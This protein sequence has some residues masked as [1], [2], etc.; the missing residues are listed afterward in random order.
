MFFYI[1]LL[2]T[3]LPTYLPTCLPACLP[4]CLSKMCLN[5]S[6]SFFRHA[7]WSGRGSTRYGASTFPQR[8]LWRSRN[9]EIANLE[10]G[11]AKVRACL[12]STSF[13]ESAVEAEWLVGAS[14]RKVELCLIWSSTVHS[15]ATGNH[16][17]NALEPPC[18]GFQGF[19]AD[20]WQR[21]GN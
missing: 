4:A 21:Q 12:K 9:R 3:Y 20:W 7:I 11:G 1:T 16:K 19:L 17:R 8:A 14:S 13:V 15:G 6:Q 10:V 5:S 18:G 2:P